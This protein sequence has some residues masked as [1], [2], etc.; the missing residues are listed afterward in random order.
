[1]TFSGS[2]SPL[3]GILAKVTYVDSW[4]PP[5]TQVSE[6]PRYFPYSLTQGA[7]G[8]NAF[9]LCSGSCF[10]LRHLNLIH[11][12]PS[13]PTSHP[14]PSLPLPLMIILFHVWC[15]YLSWAHLISLFPL[16]LKNVENEMIIQIFFQDIYWIEATYLWL[17]Y[18]VGHIFGINFQY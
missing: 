13:S 15:F 5:P 6:L 14:I 8:L 3:L 12:V 1:M 9:S 7:F 16:I 2:I 18:E 17:L 11:P 4:D 10:S